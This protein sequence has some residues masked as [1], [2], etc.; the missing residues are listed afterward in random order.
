MTQSLRP[1]CDVGIFLND[2]NDA[3]SRLQGVACVLMRSELWFGVFTKTVCGQVE[4]ELKQ[5]EVKCCSGRVS[6][7]HLDR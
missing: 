1:V 6:C 2:S 4:S 7:L 5:G 3:V